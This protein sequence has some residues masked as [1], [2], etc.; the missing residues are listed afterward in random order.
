MGLRLPHQR[1]QDPKNEETRHR[2]PQRLRP[3]LQNP[4]RNR[5]LPPLP[6]RRP[7]QTRQTQP[8][9]VLAQRRQPGRH[10][11]SARTGSPGCRNL[12]KPGGGVGELFT[13]CERA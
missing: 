11:Q 5:P 7:D 13:G 9:P 2:R 12:R 8:R 4:Q 10:R 6:H 3:L 1:P